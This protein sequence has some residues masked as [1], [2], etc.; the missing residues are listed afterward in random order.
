MLP[1]VNTCTVVKLY[2]AKKF[3]SLTLHNPFLRVCF[4]VVMLAWTANAIGW[5][6]F[7]KK[8]QQPFL[9]YTWAQRVQ[10]GP[11]RVK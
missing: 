1:F 5:Q 8:S 10:F 2:C 7:C 4:C 9:R 6:A 11:G 3:P